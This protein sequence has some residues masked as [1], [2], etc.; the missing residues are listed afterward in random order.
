MVVG[1]VELADDADRVMPGLHA[2]ELDALVGMKQLAAGQIG[3]E[4][5]MPPGAAEF[6]VGRELQADRGLL[7]HDLLDLHVLDLAQVVGGD[8]ALLQLGARLLDARRPQQAADL[9]GAERGFGSLHGLYSRDLKL[10]FS[11]RGA[12]DAEIAFEHR[13]IGLQRAA[14][15][16]M[17]DRAALQYH[18]AVGQP[19]NLLRI[20]LDD[21]RADAAGA[22][23]GAERLRAVPRR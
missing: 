10:V 4:V 23:D 22:G 16:I 11:V 3:E 2:R 6:A 19:Q 13:G 8:L 15:R 17:D 18:N 20:L 12:G 1:E 21:D 14:R 5:E 9:V 7:V